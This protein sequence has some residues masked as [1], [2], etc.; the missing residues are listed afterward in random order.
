[1]ADFAEGEGAH[2]TYVPTRGQQLRP[3]ADA[4]ALARLVSIVRD[5][6]PD[7]VHTHTAKAG[8]VGRLTA[9]V[10]SRPRPSIVHTYHG[11]VLG[12]Y[13]GHTRSRVYRS[14]ERALASHSDCLVGVSNATVGELVRL[15]VAPRERFRVIPLGV[16][17]EPFL[18]VDPEPGGPLRRELGVGPDQVLATYVGRIVPIKRLDVLVRALAV[19]RAQ[20]A[21]VQLA[22]VGDGE[23]RPELERLVSELGVAQA[24]HLLGYRRDLARV[25]QA[26]D[27]YVLSSDNEGMSQSLIEGEGA[28][29]PVAATGV[30][31]VP[32][33]VTPETGILVGR[34]DHHAL[35]DAIARLA[36][37]RDLRLRLGRAARGRALAR[38]SA[39]RLVADTDDL[40]RELLDARRS[41]RAG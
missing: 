16:A 39:E 10:E 24:V 36:G 15:G 6:R 21:R 35:G 26:S 27:M 37:D 14:L 31:G 28:A 11:H 20:R 29:R 5:F 38:Y 40:Y 22:V 8:F 23:L 9:I 32:E 18:Q 2:L 1:M 34:G 12:D 19:A 3:V 17:M 25:A 7:L 4:R 13:F 30:G 41:P 33:V